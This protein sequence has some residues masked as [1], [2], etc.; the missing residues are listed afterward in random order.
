M[1]GTFCGMLLYT[2]FFIAQGINTDQH[3]SN[4][5]KGNSAAIAKPVVATIALSGMNTIMMFGMLIE[6]VMT[7]RL[8]QG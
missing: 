6:S 1:Y 3:L 5:A 7:D 2:V 8:V 4:S